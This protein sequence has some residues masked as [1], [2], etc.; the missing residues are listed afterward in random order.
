MEKPASKRLSPSATARGVMAFCLTS[1][2]AACAGTG[3]KQ[4]TSS[5]FD[6]PVDAALT[7]FYSTDAIYGAT[8]VYDEDKYGL[9]LKVTPLPDEALPTIAP[10]PLRTTR[11]IASLSMDGSGP[12][13][14]PAGKVYY[15]ISP[16]TLWAEKDDIGEEGATIDIFSRRTGAPTT[17]KVGQSGHLATG[18][19][20]YFVD[21]ILILSQQ[22]I[23]WSLEPD[24]NETA[25]L[26]V[27]TDATD[28][29]GPFSEADCVRI[30]RSA[31]VSGYKARFNNSEGTITYQ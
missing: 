8:A 4:S 14:L 25:W 20:S 24:T 19:Y 30:N 3:E 16:F 5:S 12:L 10:A 6:F 1:M 15:S 18:P 9:T 17:A 28:E 22:T 7:K 29:E 13:S 27:N 21:D 26:C 11:Q 2:L 31:A 23:S